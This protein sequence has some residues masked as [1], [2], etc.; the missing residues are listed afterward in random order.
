MIDMI[1]TVITKFLL[2]KDGI[3]RK[4]SRFNKFVIK[5]VEEN[6]DCI[7]L[8]I[9]KKIAYNDLTYFI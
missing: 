6:I 3:V 9:Q 1:P 2:N 4:I 5:V 7:H 8:I